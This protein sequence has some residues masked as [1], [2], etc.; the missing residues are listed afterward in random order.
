M[1]PLQKVWFNGNIVDYDE[2][3]IPIDTHALHYGSSVFEG[4]RAYQTKNGKVAVFRNLDHVKRF[5]YSMET[6]RMKPKFSIEEIRNAIK[7]V[8]KVNNAKDCYIRPIAFYSTGGIGL[9]PRKNNVDIAIFVVPWGKYLKEEVRVTI[10]SYAR[11]NSLITNPWAKIGG[12]YINSILATL[13]AKER[14][15]DEA[16]ML[17]LN[18][19]LAE[20]PGENVFL[21]Y[22][23]KNLAVTPPQGSILP[24]IT[25]D[26]IMKMLREE[27]GFTVI[28]RNITI[29]EI[30]DAD[31]LF[32]VGTAAEVTPIK[33]VDGT[34]FNTKFGRELAKLY[35][36]V[37][38]G[39]LDKYL[40][41]L[42][43]VE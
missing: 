25:R 5:F 28:E 27:F 15:Y 37:V 6:L 7:E 9:D 18:G 26:T 12:M 23:D 1:E 21:I 11:P 19:Y 32:F 24:G 42:D 22:K 4:I 3:K 31:E 39:E 20:G 35:E 8:I 16:L 43:F 30:F 38:R 34:E 33:E 36:K 13:E 14:G 41:W 17:D 10:V 29:N 40:E 2:V